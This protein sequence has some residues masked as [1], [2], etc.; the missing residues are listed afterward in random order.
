MNDTRIW[1]CDLT[2]TQQTVAA[3]T[4]PMAIACIAGYSEQYLQL[5]QPI[6]LFKYPE[7]LAEAINEGT[8]PDIVGFSN[9]VWNHELG[10]SFARL[11]KEIS[12]NTIVVFGGPNYPIPDEERR[13]YL[14]AHPEIDFY[15]VGEGE[16]AFANLVRLLA[17]HGY[18][19]AAIEPLT[20]PS[21]HFVSQ[22][23]DAVLTAKQ[24]R[25]VDL[26]Q[27]PSPYQSG[28]LDEFFDGKL[29]PLLQ[30]NRGCPFSCT[31]CVEGDNYYNKIRRYSTERVGD[32]VRYIGRKMQAIRS[33]S[34]RNDLFIADSNFGMYAD[35]IDTCNA[36]R[37]TR[38]EFGWPE[39]INVA[40]G[41]NNKERVIHAAELLDGAL[42]LSGSVQSLSEDVLTN[43]KRKNISPDQL[44]DLG[45][46]ANKVGV[47]SY[48]EII[49]GLPGDSKLA[50][51]DTIR[52]VMDAGFN[53]ILPWQLMLIAG[54]ELATR[55][56]KSRYQMD[57]RYRVLPRC[58][59]S[60]PVLD[61]NLVCAEIEEV[62]V[63]N[64]TLSFDDYLECRRLNLF[65][66]VFYNDSVFAGLL[67]LLRYYQIKPFDWIE[68]MLAIK[69]SDDLK[70]VI[71]EFLQSTVDELW[72]SRQE[73]MDF[74]ADEQTIQ[75]YIRGELGRNN[76]Y[77]FRTLAITR[78][79]AAL[80]D[81]ACQ[82]A[83][84]LLE[85]TGLLNPALRQ[86]ID[87]LLAYHSLRIY[88]IFESPESVPE[89][90]FHF[91]F[92]RFEQQQNSLN[93][94]EV[95]FKGEAVT[96]KFPLDGSQ[97]ELIQRNLAVHG[98][99]SVGIARILS[100]VFVKRLYRGV[101]MLQSEPV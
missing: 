24:E 58:F 15:V 31:F 99:D 79:I 34:N 65:V 11:F 33:T 12:P 100:R 53:I 16:I 10:L 4:M 6:R 48:S 19:K 52:Q 39:Y 97:I 62:C 46:H 69:P 68:L 17:E 47:N 93:F 66:A 30:T 60:Y 28:R 96:Y 94:E 87:E 49:L 76:L 89:A 59:G 64:S 2:Y 84:N 51:F 72:T 14:Q 22:A 85:Q 75:R 26:N 74:C 36:L 7:A 81:M 77:Y 27:I 95:R 67:K 40:T 9:Y 57:V 80:R 44:I 56:E 37:D 25:M 21:V 63:A 82:A 86:F 41:K 101:E 70:S 91:D 3:D 50:H 29:M 32:D 18:V 73:L 1:L 71:D 13:D 61:R 54:S 5:N 98:T 55:K 20:P 45:L 43:I 88:G 23:G 78:H 90:Q 42:R 38:N 8:L 83:L 35:D 92:P